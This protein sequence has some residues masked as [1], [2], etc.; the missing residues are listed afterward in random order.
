[1]PP[2]PVVREWSDAQTDGGGEQASAEHRLGGVVAGRA[3]L[4]VAF[5][6]E[7]LEQVGVVVAQVRDR[8]A[9]VAGSVSASL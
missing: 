6:L 1:M 2:P 3:C 5:V 4:A 7:S 9:V 8:G